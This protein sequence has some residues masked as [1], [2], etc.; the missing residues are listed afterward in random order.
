M[1]LP[2]I[3][4]NNIANFLYCLSLFIF[5]ASF[6]YDF[7]A[8]FLYCSL[9]SYRN[10][11]SCRNFSL[12]RRQRRDF[13]YFLL[14]P[15]RALKNDNYFCYNNWKSDDYLYGKQHG[16]EAINQTTKLIQK[17]KQ[18]DKERQLL[19]SQNWIAIT[20]RGAIEKSP[21]LLL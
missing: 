16:K 20:K 2:I 4:F 9:Q 8:T 19:L 7:F 18:G 1:V 3:N 21:I 6:Q 5:F 15:I 13:C 17:M 10:S 14:L 11:N 12:F